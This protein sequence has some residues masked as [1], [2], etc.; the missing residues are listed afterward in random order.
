MKKN[1][2]MMLCPVLVLLLVGCGVKIAGNDPTAAGGADLS[3]NS[4]VV[5]T[6]KIQAA[7][8]ENDTEIQL[9]SIV[10]LTRVNQLDT[11]PA[12][13]LFY[14]DSGFQYYFPSIK[15]EYIECQFSNGD[16][17]K[18]TE[19]L[20]NGTVSVSDLDAYDIQYWMVNKAGNYINSLDKTK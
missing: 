19:A 11:C 6:E 9:V 20:K 2:A 3:T 13:E 7:A 10:D 5:S 15:S 1:I 18:I 4:E 14:E 12:L 16:T 8:A 17:M